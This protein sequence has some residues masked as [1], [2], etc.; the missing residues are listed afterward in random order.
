MLAERGIGDADV[1]QYLAPTLRAL[2][3]TLV[4]GRHGPCRGSTPSSPARGSMS[5]TT[6]STER[7]RRRCSAASSRRWAVR[8]ALRRT[9]CEGYD[10]SAEA[11][12]R[13]R[14]DRPLIVTVDCGTAAHEPLPSASAGLDVI[15]IDH[16]RAPGGAAA[17]DRRRQSQ[18]AG[19][20]GF[21]HLAAVGVAFLLAVAVRRVAADGMRRGLSRILRRWLDLVALGTVCDMVPPTGLNRAFVVQG[22]GRRR[23]Q[24]RAGGDRRRRRGARASSAHDFGF[25]IGL[26]INAG[27]RVG[28]ADLGARLLSSDDPAEVAE[29]AARL[30]AFNQRQQIEAVLERALQQALTVNGSQADLG[31]RRG[32]V[33]GVVGIASRLVERFHKPAIVAVADGKAVASCR[34]VAGVDLGRAIREGAAA[35]VLGK[36]A[37]MR[38]PAG[39]TVAADRPRRSGSSAALPVQTGRVPPA[40]RRYASP[41][42][43]ASPACVADWIAGLDRLAPFGAVIPSRCS[44]S[45]RRACSGRRAPAQHLSCRLIDQRGAG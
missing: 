30:D 22:P 18:P 7:P 17:G 12:L 43:S 8:R 19:R 45:R 39:F 29:V 16:H 23:Q 2:L 21:G 3:P 20:S 41:P 10:R 27:G 36:A 6:T 37:A 13:L 24:C 11:L 42:A 1:L 15:V 4:A 26:R 33:R 38:W 44:P 5:S 25:V 31:R 9:V 28:E 40:V 14:D 32:L 35:G 34:S